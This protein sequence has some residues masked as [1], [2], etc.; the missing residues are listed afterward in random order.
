MN[1]TT[2]SDSD[3][4]S[5]GLQF[6][7]DQDLG[8]HRIKTRTGFRYVDCHRKPVRD[9]NT[10]DRITALVIPPAWTDVWICQA[11][12]GHIQAVGRDAKGRKQ[13]RYHAKWREHRDSE[14]FGRL[15]T[16]GEKLPS[17]RAEVEKELHRH[18]LPREKVLAAM[19]A[20]LE[21][22]N[23]RIGND[24]YAKANR[25]YGLTTLRDRH[26]SISSTGLRLR[27]VGKSG[28]EHRITLQDRRLA[29]VVKRCQD[30]PGQRLFV[31]IDDEG[32]RHAITSTEIN[33]WLT[34]ITGEHITAKDFR[35]W[36]GTV[37]AVANLRHLPQPESE[38][39]AKREFVAAVDAVA[40]MLG[41]TRAVARASYIHPV[42]FDAFRDGS[43]MSI[44]VDA[45][46]DPTPGG[47][48]DDE[49]VTLAL[50]KAA[51]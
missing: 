13:Y 27:F 40:E 30:L 20:L 44:D 8:I 45:A 47:L 22:T 33:G 34:E 25:S 51:G 4:S 3:P 38:S 41:N 5:I 9:P 37:G 18:G 48:D 50:L 26:I 32:T 35:T 19:I 29:K 28:K 16:F 49:R 46:P 24:E 36:F 12:N 21:K 11:E 23:I 7:S 2:E 43:L 10:I 31:Y 42:V 17:I 14:K 1:E 15:A 6:S 39:M